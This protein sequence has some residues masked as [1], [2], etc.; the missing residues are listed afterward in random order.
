MSSWLV[1][2]DID[3]GDMDKLRL[4]GNTAWGGCGS[5]LAMCAFT[6]DV[7]EY[8]EAELPSMPGLRRVTVAS[9]MSVLMMHRA[10]V[11]YTLTDD[12]GALG[13]VSYEVPVGQGFDIRSD[14]IEWSR[15]VDGRIVLKVESTAAGNHDLNTSFCIAPKPPTLSVSGMEGD[16][17]MHTDRTGADADLNRRMFD[18]WY[19]QA[20][21][22]IRRPQIHKV[23]VDPGISVLRYGAG[24]NPLQATLPIYGRGHKIGISSQ[25]VNTGSGT[26][27][28]RLKV[29][30]QTL[31]TLDTF[32]VTQGTIIRGA[33]AAVLPAGYRYCDLEVYVPASGGLDLHSVAVFEEVS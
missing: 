16:G 19:Q 33:S 10:T 22:G 31:I 4:Q 12:T 15:A 24:T 20:W 32:P 2:A 11:Q 28:L 18:I 23:M 25:G 3:Q 1:G 13:T 9:F 17:Y 8:A 27:E 7:S 30:G 14:D 21:N 6:A 26:P 5:P 29:D